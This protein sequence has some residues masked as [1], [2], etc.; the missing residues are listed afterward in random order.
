[1]HGLASA[2]ASISIPASSEAISL[3]GRPVKGNKSWR[4][5]GMRR[6]GFVAMR[7]ADCAVVVWA[8]PRIWANSNTE[9]LTEIFKKCQSLYFSIH[10]YALSILI[11]QELLSTHLSKVSLDD[12]VPKVFTSSL[13]IDGRLSYKL[14][15]CGFHPSLWSRSDRLLALPPQMRGAQGCIAT[16]SATE[17][18]STPAALMAPSSVMIFEMA[19]ETSPHFCLTVS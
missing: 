16:A 15:P 14:G 2:K 12:W 1:M 13:I 7:T 3:S 8:L 9:Y 5:T 17:T 11:F 6:V 19:S 4:F 10:I 18:L